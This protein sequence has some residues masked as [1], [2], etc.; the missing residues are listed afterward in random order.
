MA[1][2]LPREMIGIAGLR[3][4]EGEIVTEEPKSCENI[5]GPVM[6][7]E[8]PKALP[9]HIRKELD[10]NI[11]GSLDRLERLKKERAALEDF[12]MALNIHSRLKEVYARLILYKE[13]DSEMRKAAKSEEYA[14]ASRLKIERDIAKDAAMSSLQEVEEEFVGNMNDLSLSTIK[15]D[16]FMSQKSTRSI[17]HFGDSDQMSVMGSPFKC[18]SSNHNECSIQEQSLHEHDLSH[19]S[20]DQQ[21]D[22]SDVPQVH[23]L[24]GIEHAEELP[25]PEDISKDISTDLIHKVEMLFGSYISKCL[26]SKVKY[27]L[28]SIVDNRAS[29]II[30]N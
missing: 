12:D 10:L 6:N 2:V 4:I 11:Q 16:S 27:M 22:N 8:L 25:V 24:A 29:M 13:R 30:T 5:Q 9:P 1:F 19:Q 14:A 20:E 7:I 18:N 26:F 17:Q 28:R 21:D 23:P 15:N 3:L